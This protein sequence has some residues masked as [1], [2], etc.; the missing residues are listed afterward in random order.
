MQTVV[1]GLQSKEALEFK[2]QKR[3]WLSHVSL[4]CK[5]TEPTLNWSLNTQLIRKGLCSSAE[6]YS[7]DIADIVDRSYSKVIDEVSQGLERDEIEYIT[8]GYESQRQF[9]RA[10]GFKDVLISKVQL[11][12]IK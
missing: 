7:H 8:L 2:N 10:E 9:S 5:L 6:K 12:G 4:P 11:L 1:I 3:E